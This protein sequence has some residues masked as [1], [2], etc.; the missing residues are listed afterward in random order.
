MAGMGAM[1]ATRILWGQFLL[2]LGIALAFVWGATQWTAWR[3][4]HQGE[5][6]PPWLMLGH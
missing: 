6:G 5:L 1:S 4:G 3:L 2:V